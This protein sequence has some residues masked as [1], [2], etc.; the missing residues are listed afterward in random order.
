MVD[1]MLFIQY[2]YYYKFPKALPPMHAHARSATMPPGRRLSVDRGA[3]RYRTLSAVV[4][5][6]AAAAARQDELGEVHQPSPYPRRTSRIRHIA[7]DN[8]REQDEDEELQSAMV[9]SFYSEGGRDVRPRRV[10]WSIDRQSRAAS[11]G[12]SVREPPGLTPLPNDP[13]L[14]S[15]SENVRHEVPFSQSS[16]NVPA[17]STESLTP[18]IV[19]TRGTRASRRGSTMVFLGAWALFGLGALTHSRGIPYS[20]NRQSIGRVLATVEYRNGPVPVASENARIYQRD[21]G[22]RNLDNVDLTFSG[23]SDIP[24]GPSHDD[25]E[26]SPEQVLGRLFAWLCTTLY[27]TS[28]LP[29]IWKN[30]RYHSFAEWCT[31]IDLSPSLL[32]SQ[33]R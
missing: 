11:V 32:E 22:T 26:P 33:W 10:S 23:H 21:S 20:D 24:E 5:N 13:L 31:R 7:S 25:H 29:Q 27:I 12:R 6:V 4:S 2:F 16:H 30:V 3:A 9:E 15:R 17:S 28:R 8:G 1:C 19:S 14:S 18:T